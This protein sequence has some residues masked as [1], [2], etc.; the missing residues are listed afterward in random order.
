[1]SRFDQVNYGQGQPDPDQE[2]LK[3]L[4][5]AAELQRREER[6]K[7]MLNAAALENE[8]LT[9]EEVKMDEAIKVSLTRMQLEY[10]KQTTPGYWRRL[11]A[12]L[13][14]K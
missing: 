5:R 10:E 13:R 9:R 2:K 7:I 6:R 4:F 8:P 1:M 11:W 3:P 12:A 14:G